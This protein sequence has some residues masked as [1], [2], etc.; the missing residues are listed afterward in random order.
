MSKLK[1]LLT[2]DSLYDHHLYEGS[3]LNPNDSNKN[4]TC[5]K[6]SAGGYFLI[7]DI[8]QKTDLSDNVE[9]TTQKPKPDNQHGY[10]VWQSFDD[11]WRVS[12]KMGYGHRPQHF[13]TPQ[14]KADVWDNKNCDIVVFDDAAMSYRFNS[15]NWPSFIFENTHSPELIISKMSF[16]TT[17]GDL[18]T[19]L[20]DNNFTENMIII[21]SADDLRR[22]EVK[23]SQG[24]SW[25]RTIQDV[26]V[27]IKSNA[28]LKDLKLCRHLIIT[29]GSEGALWIQPQDSFGDSPIK[30]IFDPGYQENAWKTKFNGEVLGR[31]SCFTS[32]VIYSIANFMGTPPFNIKNLDL[33]DGII[34]GLS[35]MRALLK[36]GH[37]D[38][39]T[40]PAFP[41]ETIGHT[42]STVKPK[43]FRCVSLPQTAFS[44]S[45]SWSLIEG[46]MPD[47]SGPLYGRARQVALYGPAVLQDIPFG[48]FGQLYTVDR[49][50]I[51]SL[52]G[53]KELITN[54][55]AKQKQDKPLSLGV[56]GPPGAGKS[57]GIKQIAKGIMGEDVSILEFN[58]SQFNDPGMLSDALHQV[59]DEVLKGGTPVVFWDEFDSRELFWLQYLLA[60]MQ[61]GAFLE[62]QI[63]HPIGKC[64]FVFA[65]GTSYTMENFEPV[66][67]KHEKKDF[68][69]EQMK[70]NEN[71]I[72]VFKLKKGP[73]FVSRLHGYLNVLGPNRRQI[74]N[75][76]TEQWEDDLS[77]NC[78][79][80][81]RALL[82]RVM[83]GV[84]DK[85]QRFD[86]DFGM[87]NGFIKIDKYKHGSR[88]METI[89][90]LTKKKNFNGLL[91]SNL[92]PRSQA[93]IH[94]KYDVF[95]KLIEQDKPFKNN[96]DTFAENIHN[97]YKSIAAKEGW[98]EP[99]AIAWE[100]LTP[101]FQ[102]DNKAAARR[103]PD[104]FSLISLQVADES[105]TGA[106]DID[107][108][109]KL[110]ED[111]IDV[112]GEAEHEL[113]MKE[114]IE[115]G[116]VYGNKRDDEKKIQP[117]IAPYDEL[118]EKEKQKDKNAVRNY[119]TLLNDAGFGFV[120][121]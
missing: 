88:S 118:P 6:T 58:L 29:F 48:S 9:I 14:K 84:F 54:Y 18:W 73:D 94:V 38:S 70:R 68:P 16:P 72:N 36:S 25:E 56:F 81:R 75:L 50:E 121:E 31:S 92:P 103:I 62:G 117:C 74:F 105:D 39:K 41:Y 97:F 99:W 120:F 95:L 30:M 87:L 52:N 102:E 45:I 8:L 109:K 22:G 107:L 86:I 64:I 61:D 71:A 42:I 60:P 78:F 119:L 115:N 100:K 116:W 32:G 40:S 82:L 17:K 51:E 28:A 49:N 34:S 35:A 23:I 113:W 2:G 76:D 19:Y 46:S 59:R 47:E 66:N 93:A 108:V 33:C 43:E 53:I 13:G 44:A 15:K 112:L 101:P 90:R 24:I 106:I 4:G 98:N 27:E 5:V 77:D 89:I 65:G 96:C 11:V 21:V 7:A 110:V 83:S 104:I 63:S 1:L 111:N 80:L 57:F 10:A 26:L 37:G 114:K 67:L 12:H 69:E 55:I 79:P 20:R 3:C 85:H 91:R